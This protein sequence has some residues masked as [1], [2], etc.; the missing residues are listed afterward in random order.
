MLSQMSALEHSQDLL[1]LV[2]MLLLPVP[3]FFLLYLQVHIDSYVLS[4]GFA[5]DCNFTD[6]PMEFKKSIIMTVDEN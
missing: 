2:P 5:F 6:N 4:A 3:K 1:D